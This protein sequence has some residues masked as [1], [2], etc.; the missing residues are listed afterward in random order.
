MLS[1]TPEQK[2]LADHVYRRG[3]GCRPRFRSLLGT[4]TAR[5]PA[6]NAPKSS[7]LTNDRLVFAL[8][9]QCDGTSA[10]PAFRTIHPE[11][12]Q[13]SARPPLATRAAFPGPWYSKPALRS[14]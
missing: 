6:P 14:F 10:L 3:L 4:R 12:L 11:L 7:G 1:P 2:E 13:P 9:A 8:R 5:P